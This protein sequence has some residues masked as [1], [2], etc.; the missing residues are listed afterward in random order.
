MVTKT[1][2]Q[3]QEEK[4]K[5]IRANTERQKTFE[6]LASAGF[7]KEEQIYWYNR[8][9]VNGQYRVE[10]SELHTICSNKRTFDRI[11]RENAASAK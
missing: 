1:Y 2:R 6:A 7:N 8:L 11:D 10:P 4:E 9:T 5:T 3:I